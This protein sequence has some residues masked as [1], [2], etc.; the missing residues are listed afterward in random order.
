MLEVGGTYT[1]KGGSSILQLSFNSSGNS[2]LQAKGYTIEG[3]KLEYLPLIAQFP[4]KPQI[5][6]INLQGLKDSLDDFTGGVSVF[7]SQALDYTLMPDKFTL[8]IIG[9]ANAYGNYYGAN[10]SLAQALRNI[11][12]LQNLPAQYDTYFKTLNSASADEYQR[13]LKSIDSNGYLQHSQK[14]LSMQNK[15]A[16]KN[17]LHLY[18][19]GGGG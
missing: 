8:Q 16:L 18:D 17:I 11:A 9:K 7:N 12:A 1:Q 3:G 4:T 19:T 13:S 2:A 14:M 5:I 10:P 15:D 6:T